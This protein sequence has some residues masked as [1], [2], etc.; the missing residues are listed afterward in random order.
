MD[1]MA[2]LSGTFTIMWRLPAL[3]WFGV[4]LL[5]F[6]TERPFNRNYDLIS[7]G[8]ERPY[9]VSSDLQAVF[10][11]SVSSHAF[12]VTWHLLDCKGEF[13]AKKETFSTGC[14]K[15]TWAKRA[16]T[17]VRFIYYRSNLRYSHLTLLLV[18][19]YQSVI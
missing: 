19:F 6:P 5:L 1:V 12:L 10:R 11:S 13:R 14:A 9:P 8:Q 18:L 3:M 2:V 16:F 7:F 4:V 15:W 17:E